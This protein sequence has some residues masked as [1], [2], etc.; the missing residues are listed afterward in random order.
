M[1]EKSILQ[2]NG[3]VAKEEGYGCLKTLAPTEVPDLVL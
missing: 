2:V 3:H 1:A